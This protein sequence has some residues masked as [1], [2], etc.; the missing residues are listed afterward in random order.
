MKVDQAHARILREA[1]AKL[2]KL[3]NPFV[4]RICVTALS[5]YAKGVAP[6]CE[7]VES[8]FITTENK[9]AC[10]DCGKRLGIIESP[11]LFLAPS[12][13]EGENINEQKPN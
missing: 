3:G 6:Y 1:I 10:L 12:E 8:V 11:Q 13:P 2:T 7:C 5:N 4:T 9:T